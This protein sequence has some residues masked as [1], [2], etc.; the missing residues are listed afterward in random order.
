MQRYVKDVIAD[1]KDNPSKWCPVHDA[2]VGFTGI[3]RDSVEIIG[4][5]NTRL[6]SIVYLRV[7]GQ[8]L[9]LSYLDKWAI[10]SAVKAW[11]KKAPIEKMA[12]IKPAT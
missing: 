8:A 1:I 7:H 3:A 10:E 12:E 9:S 5:G 6:L 2:Y 11:C 4:Y